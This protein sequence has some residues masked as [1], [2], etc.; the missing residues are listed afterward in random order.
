MKR[1]RKISIKQFFLFFPIA[2]LQV[3]L[4]A[5]EPVTLSSSNLKHNAFAS[6]ISVCSEI[7]GI[8]AEAI[9]S[10]YKAYFNGWDAPIVADPIDERWYGVG[11][12]ILLIAS[13][14]RV[15]NNLRECLEK[16]TIV[17]DDLVDYVETAAKRLGESL[18]ALEGL[19]LPSY[20]ES[21][22]TS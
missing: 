13:D 16:H 2:L 3:K 21:V 12:N 19:K 8:D 5:A 20:Y 7:D 18:G 1:R 4:A 10:F 15:G 6:R 14:G 22:S 11:Q 9:S 17:S